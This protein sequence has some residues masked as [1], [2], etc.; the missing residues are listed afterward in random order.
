MT[1]LGGLGV[2]VQSADCPGKGEATLRRWRLPPRKR[3]SWCLLQH[4]RVH[5]REG[6]TAWKR[7]PP[8]RER[9]LHAQR[10]TPPRLHL[11]VFFCFVLGKMRGHESDFRSFS[12]ALRN[13]RKTSHVPH[14]PHV[15]KH[16]D[17]QTINES[18]TKFKIHNLT[19]LSVTG[20]NFGGLAGQ[21]GFIHLT[22]SIN[23]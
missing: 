8:Q 21:S 19:L 3:R 22:K 13:I 4:G 23:K 9:L 7:R 10:A 1:H 5:G 2:K 16:S 11:C 14:Y 15:P 17:P 18:E 20:G 12:L 6:A